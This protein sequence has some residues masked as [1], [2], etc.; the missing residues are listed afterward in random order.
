MWDPEL[1]GR[2]ASERNRPF[3]E[4]VARVGAV[5]PRR[6]VDLGC[7]DGSLTETLAARWPSASVLG[8][9]SSKSMLADAA[10]RKTERM[11]F[12]LQ[13]IQDWQPDGPVDVLVSNAALQWVPQHLDLLPRLVGALAPGGWLAIQ[14]PGNFEAPS[15][16]ALRELCGSPRWSGQL[17]GAGRWPSMPAPAD[18]VRELAGL[19]CVVDSWETTY[20]Q[21][22]AGPDPVLTWMRGTALRPVLARLSPSDAASF[23]AELGP[24]LREAYPAQEYGTV[25]PFRRIFAVAQARG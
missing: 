20:A 5:S 18:Y 15:H 7:G 3:H 2:F 4:L 22:L 24:L 16:A 13:Q 14:V 10:P 21:V 8:V 11:S 25:L 17:S 6:V 12:L 9:D 19:G 23:E 1:Y